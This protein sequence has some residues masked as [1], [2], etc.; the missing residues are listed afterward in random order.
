MYLQTSISDTEHFRQIAARIY[1]NCSTG[2]ARRHDL[3]I[4]SSLACI[5][6][7]VNLLYDRQILSKFVNSSVA[8][9]QESM[10]SWNSA[11]DARRFLRFPAAF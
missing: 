7:K 2:D 10:I 11:M 5:G 3:F 1:P 4:V 9:W 6:Y 8:S